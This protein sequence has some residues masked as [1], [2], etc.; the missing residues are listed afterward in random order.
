VLAAGAAAGRAQ[1]VESANARQFSISAGGMASGFEPGY[2]PGANT[3]LIGLGTYVDVHFT[4]WIQVEGEGRWLYFN[5]YQ[6]E[7]EANY[8]IGP[9]VPIKHFGR[10]Q[11]YGKA[12][13]GVGKMTYP[14]SY[15]YGTFTALAY[16]GTLDYKL[17]RKLT[18]RAVDF[19]Y[20]QWPK[21]VDPSTGKNTQMCPYG[22][23]VGMAYRVF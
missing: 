18:L 3:P 5:Q 9:R 10:A 22:V 17:S 23:S 2:E 1:V 4:H 14:F 8:M 20:Q 12:L 19:E 7:H 16:G 13:I 21:W 11:V 15:G 6:G